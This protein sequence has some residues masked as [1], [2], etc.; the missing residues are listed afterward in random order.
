MGLLGTLEPHD[1]ALIARAVARTEGLE[2]LQG[3]I[4]DSRKLMKH[5]HGGLV[6]ILVLID[7]TAG[8]LHVVILSGLIL[9]ATLHKKHS[10]IGTVKSEH[11]AVDG[12]VIIRQRSHG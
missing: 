7:E 12:Y 1:I 6:E 2:L 10:Q 5:T 3:H 4:F 8:E 9:A 11:Y